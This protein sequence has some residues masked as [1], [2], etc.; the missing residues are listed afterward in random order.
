MTELDGADEEREGRSVEGEAS[1]S[2]FAICCSTSVGFW[3]Q[4]LER[5]KTYFQ[6]KARRMDGCIR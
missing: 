5:A 3:Y 4:S 2:T 6:P 1:F